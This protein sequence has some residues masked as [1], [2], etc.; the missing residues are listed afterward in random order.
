MHDR[1]PKQARVMLMV[2]FARAAIF[3]NAVDLCLIF[4]DGPK[5]EEREWQITSCYNFTT[6]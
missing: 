1:E 6:R 3:V 5:N 4:C 2:A